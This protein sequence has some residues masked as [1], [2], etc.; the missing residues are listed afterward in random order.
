MVENLAAR[1]VGRCAAEDIINPQTGEVIVKLNE[2]ISVE[3]ANES[4]NVGI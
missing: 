4:E 3:K 1:I 2:M